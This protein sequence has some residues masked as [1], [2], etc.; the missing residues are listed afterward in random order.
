M[1]DQQPPDEDETERERRMVNIELW[2][3]PRFLWSAPASGWSM[4][5]V[6]AR[7]AEECFEFGPAQLQSG[8][9]IE[10]KGVE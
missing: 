4:A 10:R 6:D 2:L 5:L 8:S 9:T 7:K 3:S 1:N